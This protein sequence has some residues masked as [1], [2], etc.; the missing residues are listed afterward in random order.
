MS[1]ATTSATSAPPSIASSQ[2]LLELENVSVTFGGDPAIDSISLCLHSGE[3]VGIIGQNGA[4]KTTLL[5]T[6]LGLQKPTSGNLTRTQNIRTGYIPQRGAHYNGIVPISVLEVVTLGSRHRSAEHARQALEQVHM[7]DFAH[8][9]FTELSGG[10]Q[11]R[12]SIAKALA[13][14]ADLLILDE[15]TTGI[16]ERSQA[17]FYSLLRSLQEKGITIIMVSHEVDTVLSLV[18][19][20]ICLNQ[21]VVYDGPPEHFESDKYLPDRNQ[22]IHLHHNHQTNRRHHA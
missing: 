17:S 13:G 8:R 1:S 18:T 2:L 3:F 5:K 11:Q 6:I 19:R 7:Q 12:I 14:N 9:V 22:H 21:Q 16:D 20:V 15:P 4:G 10:Q